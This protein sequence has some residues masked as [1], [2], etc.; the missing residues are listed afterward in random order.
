M[1]LPLLKVF[2]ALFF[3]TVQDAS[4]S[5]SIFPVPILESS[6]FPWS[7][8]SFYCWMVLT[9]LDLCAEC[10][11]WYWRV[12]ASGHPLVD[13]A[14]NYM[15]TS[16][17]VFIYISINILDG[18]DFMDMTPK[19]EAKKKKKTDKLDLIKIKKKSVHQ[20][21]KSRKLPCDPAIPLL[22]VWKWKWT[23]SHSWKWSHSVVSDSM[24]P[25]GL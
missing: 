20:R 4:G 17:P 22:S 21:T 2:W 19:R 13:R 8:C 3:C 11:H 1:L 25:H 7:P 23:W 15:C 16:Y 9:K 24:R 12:I 6:I 10:A 14:T 18:N 5:F